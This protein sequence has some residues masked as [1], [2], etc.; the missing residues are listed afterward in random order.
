MNHSVNPSEVMAEVQRELQERQL[1]ELVQ[2]YVL[3]IQGAI[4]RDAAARHAMRNL[5]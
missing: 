3:P 1:E 5:S 4:A 2:K